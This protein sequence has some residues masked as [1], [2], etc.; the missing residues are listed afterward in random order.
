[1]VTD[2]IDIATEKAL[3]PEG[4]FID[5]AVCVNCKEYKDGKCG[6]KSDERVN[7]TD[8]CANW[9][10]TREDAKED[11]KF[12]IRQCYEKIIKILKK[13]CDLKENQYPIVALWIIGTYA[14]KE[15]TTFPYLFFNAMKGSGKS[16]ILK[17][18][19]HLCHEGKMVNNLSEAVLFRTASQRTL[20]IDEFE[21]VHSKEK[22][23]LRELLNSAYKKGTVV[24]RAIKSNSKDGE[25]WKIESYDVYCPIIMANIGGME[26]VLSDRCIPLILDKSGKKHITRL[27]ELYDIDIDIFSVK[28]TFSVVS[29]VSLLNSK[30]K[31]EG[32][33]NYVM[34]L[35]NDTTNDITTL[36]T[37]T[38]PND[39]EHYLYKKID[40]S[41]I[42]S[43]NLEL[44]FPLFIIAEAIGLDVL[45]QCIEIAKNIVSQKKDD[46]WM[47]NRDVNFINFLAN[48]EELLKNLSEDKGFIKESII[49]N[50]YRIWAEFDEKEEE[51]RWLNSKWIGRAL[52]RLNFVDEKRRI[53]SGRMVNINFDKVKKQSTL[54][55]TDEKIV[56]EKL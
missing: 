30:I 4:S 26:E 8:T 3:F 39:K 11:S 41:G 42:V 50:Q 36:T 37:H 22:G 38:T 14:H 18:I 43:R 7:E 34:S 24:E 44:F 54:F 33:N 6:I 23:I 25:K 19:L 29:V 1:M 46:D 13:Y 51:W 35:Y 5:K 55:K 47:E 32:W 56:T 52:K 53:S 21:H 17:L 48:S 28:R 16:R 12:L 40:E 20:G 10:E 45:D 49:L 31:G 15:F 2:D 27:L 9:D